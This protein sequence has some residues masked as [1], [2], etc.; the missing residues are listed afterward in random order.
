MFACI[1][2][3]N[4]KTHNFNVLILKNFIY[5]TTSDRAKFCAERVSPKLQWRDLVTERLSQALR[6]TDRHTR[7]TH[8]S[9]RH[10]PSQET[11]IFPHFPQQ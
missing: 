11:S 8:C 9:S 3:I 2:T 5:A 4:K 7:L 1:R 6:Y 10:F